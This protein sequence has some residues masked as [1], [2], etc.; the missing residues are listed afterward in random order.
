MRA[1][2]GILRLALSGSLFED[3]L[4]ERQIR[5]RLAQPAG[6]FLKLLETLNLVPLQAAE[7]LA[8]TM[9]RKPRHADRSNRFSDRATL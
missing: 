2:L 6:L 5:H 7:L 3:Q 9:I 1:M 4:L 8:P